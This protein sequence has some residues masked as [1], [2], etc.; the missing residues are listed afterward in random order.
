M[1]FLLIICLQHAAWLQTAEPP[2]PKIKFCHQFLPPCRVDEPIFFGLDLLQSS[3]VPETVD[4]LMDRWSTLLKAIC[5]WRLFSFIVLGFLCSSPPS[6]PERCINFHIFFF[7]KKGVQKCLD[8]S[9][10]PR[11]GIWTWSFRALFRI[12]HFLGGLQ[13]LS[14]QPPTENCCWYSHQGACGSTR[15]NVSQCGHPWPITGSPK[16]TSER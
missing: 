3:S 14:R 1:F 12:K 5:R 16:C 13:H 8:K 6:L 10:P 9:P 11:K 2:P 15:V 4:W 7:F